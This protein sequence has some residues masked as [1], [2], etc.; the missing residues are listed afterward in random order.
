M[1]LMLDATSDRII[2]LIVCSVI[3]NLYGGKFAKLITQL[4]LYCNY[5]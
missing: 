2:T 5:V 1:D 4:F 3:V